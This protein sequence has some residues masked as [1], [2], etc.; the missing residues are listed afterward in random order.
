MVLPLKEKSLFFGCAVCLVGTVT[1]TNFFILPVLLQMTLYTFPIIYLGCHLSLK[2]AE[3]DPVT[4]DKPNKSE[5]M[6]KRDAMMFPVF[7][8][9]ALLVLYVAY[10]FLDPWY[11]NMLLTTYLSCIGAV[12][13]AETFYTFISPFLPRPTEDAIALNIT[14][15]PLASKDEPWDFR[16]NWLHIASYIVAATMS[17]VWFATKHWA[18]HNGFAIAFCI[19]AIALV[20]MGD[21][22]VATILLC[23]LFVYDIFWVFG[24]EVMVTVAKSFEGPA[25]LIFPLNFDPWQQSILGLGDVVVPGIFISMC[26]RFDNYMHERA[27]KKHANQSTEGSNNEEKKE[28][29][30]VA[31]NSDSCVKNLNEVDIHEKFG[32]F[33]FWVVMISYELGLLTTGIVMVVFKHPQPALLYLVPYCLLSMFG[34]ATLNGE[35]KDLLAYKEDADVVEAI[36]DDGGEGVDAATDGVVEDMKKEGA[37]GEEGVRKTAAGGGSQ[38]QTVQEE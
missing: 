23:G 37:G 4:G 7:G 15:W 2:Q 8:S 32:K 36:T 3:V 10:K 5:S 12:A 26:L 21:F 9:V 19:Q 27:L 1:L 20:S 35:V 25:K 24:T 14:C 22:K 18:L 16:A 38:R 34:A 17:V 31:G 30:A 28:D 33:Y 13:V 11:V 29:A 6:S